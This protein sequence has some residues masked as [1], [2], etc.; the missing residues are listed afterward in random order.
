MVSLF[1]TF[2]GFTKTRAVSDSQMSCVKIGRN[3]VIDRKNQEVNI[4]K[5]Y[6]QMFLLHVTPFKFDFCF[7]Q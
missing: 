7:I 5:R 2:M 1:C 4:H 6:I 3:N